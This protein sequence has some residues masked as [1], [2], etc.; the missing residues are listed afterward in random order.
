MTKPKFAVGQRVYC[1]SDINNLRAVTLDGFCE[2]QNRFR[3][4]DE[5]CCYHCWV[6]EEYLQ[7]TKAELLEHVKSELEKLP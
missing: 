3:F 2:T 4:Y 5:G 7:P 6:G 1:C